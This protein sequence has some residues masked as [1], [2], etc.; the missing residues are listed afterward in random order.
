M[1]SNNSDQP[2]VSATNYKAYR[3]SKALE[4]FDC[5]ERKNGEIQATYYVGE[6]GAGESAGSVV[7]KLPQVSFSEVV[8][9]TIGETMLNYVCKAVQEKS[10]KLGKI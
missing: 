8:P 10:S 4:Y 1:Y 2:G 9:D 3:S 6:F 7:W 5:E